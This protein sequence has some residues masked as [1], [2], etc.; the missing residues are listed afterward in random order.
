MKA[1]SLFRFFAALGLC[2]GEITRSQDLPYT[3]A[4]WFWTYDGYKQAQFNKNLS[5][6]TISIGRQTYP[7]GICGHTNFSLVYNVNSQAEEFSCLIGVED[8]DHPD[9]IAR[10]DTITP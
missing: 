8:E 10:G 6:N 3:D 4:S 2:G 5:D 9:D 7:E 1:L